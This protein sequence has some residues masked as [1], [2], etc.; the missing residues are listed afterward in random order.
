MSLDAYG[1]FK[2]AITAASMPA[3]LKIVGYDQQ[4]LLALCERV[5]AY[6]G[7]QKAII[8]GTAVAVSNILPNGVI[9]YVA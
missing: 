4:L 3:E 6:N 9:S 2:T 1:A 8:A 7:G 5:T